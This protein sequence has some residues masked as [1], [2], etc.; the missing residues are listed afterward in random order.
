MD[1]LPSRFTFRIYFSV[2]VTDERITAESFEKANGTDTGI[3]GII[4]YWY[5]VLYEKLRKEFIRC[6]PTVE[7]IVIAAFEVRRDGLVS[8]RVA[9]VGKRLLNW[10]HEFNSRNKK[11]HWPWHTDVSELVSSYR[12]CRC[13]LSSIFSARMIIVQWSLFHNDSHGP[14]C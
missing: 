7:V 13:S 14:L 5:V 6:A 3:N 4:W 12:D 1:H 11:P 2:D 9:S 8:G 10:S